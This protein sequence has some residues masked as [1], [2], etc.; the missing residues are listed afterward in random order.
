VRKRA[1]LLKIKLARSPPGLKAKRRP[2]PC[3][4]L[5]SDTVE[6]ELGHPET[7]NAA[8]PNDAWWRCVRSGQSSGN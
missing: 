7:H 6:Q 3:T 5:I 4:V 1:H 2:H 8:K